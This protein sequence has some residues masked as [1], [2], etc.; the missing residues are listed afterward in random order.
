MTEGERPT[1][2][3]PLRIAI[4]IG[5][6]RPGSVGTAV[7]Q[8]AFDIA[9]DRDDAIFELLDLGDFNLPLLDEPQPAM[10]LDPHQSLADQYTRQHTRAWSEVVASFD[11]YVFVIPEYNHGISGAQVRSMAVQVGS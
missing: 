9:R 4:I 10:L 5:S 11:G 2:A 8:W 7:G 1:I 3:P 6:I